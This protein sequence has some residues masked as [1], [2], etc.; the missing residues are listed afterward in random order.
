[1]PEKV[2]GADGSTVARFAIERRFLESGRP[3]DVTLVYA[4][5]QGDGKAREREL[6]VQELTR[7][8]TP[9]E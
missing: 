7:R 6:A 9:H 4:A 5:G 1:M 3:R 2:P 8:L